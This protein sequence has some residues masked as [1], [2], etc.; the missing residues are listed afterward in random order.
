[1][2]N[3]VKD[4]L[5][6]TNIRNRLEPHVKPFLISTLLGILSGAASSVSIFKLI[7]SPYFRAPSGLGDGLLIGIFSSSLVFVLYLLIQTDRKRPMLKLFLC[8][9]LLV[10]CAINFTTPVL[11]GFKGFEGKDVMPTLSVSAMLFPI[12]IFFLLLQPL[13]ALPIVFLSLTTSLYVTKEIKDVRKRGV[14]ALIIA[15][16]TS[17]AVFYPFFIQIFS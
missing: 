11:G 5:D 12:G 10:F 7:F 1:M 16:F 4:S 14:E 6:A 13:A 17:S 3:R 9:S 8:W 15:Y 2:K